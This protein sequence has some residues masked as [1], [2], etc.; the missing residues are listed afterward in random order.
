MVA[1]GS[2]MDA[3]TS[4]LASKYANR[5]FP[6]KLSRTEPAELRLELNVFK[7]SSKVCPAAPTECQSAPRWNFG[8][9]D[10]CT[11]RTS[12]TSLA[13]TS[14]TIVRDCCRHAIFTPK[15]PFQTALIGR[16]SSF[17]CA[18]EAIARL[19]WIGWVVSAALSE[20]T[21][22]WAAA[23]MPS[24]SLGGRPHRLKL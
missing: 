5:K 7:S 17:G 21:V 9:S 16:L 13:H 4:R 15:Q 6:T 18:F 12:R 19:G 22:R 23:A 20:I 11:S 1:S 8:P 2:D 3:G 24:K 10:W 14:P